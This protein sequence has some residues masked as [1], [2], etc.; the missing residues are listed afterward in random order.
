V[1]FSTKKKIN[2]KYEVNA[3]YGL[4]AAAI[5]MKG[6]KKYSNET[7]KVSQVEDF[8]RKVCGLKRLTPM[9]PENVIS[10]KDDQKQNKNNKMIEIIFDAFAKDEC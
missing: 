6:K 4:Q 5:E 1:V 3:N 2:R 10:N 9:K 8:E 7:Q